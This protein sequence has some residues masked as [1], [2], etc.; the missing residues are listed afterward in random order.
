MISERVKISALIVLTIQLALNFGCTSSIELTK[1]IL[2]PQF[3]ILSSD[4]FIIAGV[5]ITAKTSVD[6]L[7]FSE[8]NQISRAFDL[9]KLPF[10]FILNIIAENPNNGRSGTKNM[11]AFVSGFSGE[12]LIDGKEAGTGKISDEFEIKTTSQFPV[13]IKTDLM[14]YFSGLSYEKLIEIIFVIKKEIDRISYRVTPAV[15][16]DKGKLIPE[17]LTIV[18]SEFR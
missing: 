4:N 2:S 14:K 10:T 18:S 16:T 11:S 5:D 17:K 1:K 12:L 8:R 6:E 15:Y 9:K 13:E 3:K 7:S